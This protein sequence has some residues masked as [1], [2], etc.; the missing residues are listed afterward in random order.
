MCGCGGV[1]GCA[2]VCG[3][4]RGCA[5]VCGG[6]RGCAGV[7]GGVR[8]C[9][10]VRGCVG[11][12]VRGWVGGW[13]G[14]GG[15]VGGGWVGGLSMAWPFHSVTRSRCP[16]R[17]LCFKKEQG[18]CPDKIHREDDVQIA[19]DLLRETCEYFCIINALDV[20]AAA[21]LATRMPERATKSVSES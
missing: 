13:V 2:G 5:G 3:G 7:C 16:Q 14:G 12:W 21:F 1:R 11:A 9:A 18:T 10:G 15:E 4:V 20:C 17:D 6:V 19:L 8:G